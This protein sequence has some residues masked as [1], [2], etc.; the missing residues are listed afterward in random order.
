LYG[1]SIRSPLLFVRG[2]VR[3]KSNRIREVR[4]SLA[5]CFLYSAMYVLKVIEVERYVDR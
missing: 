5:P 3:A 2:D 1:A 4:R